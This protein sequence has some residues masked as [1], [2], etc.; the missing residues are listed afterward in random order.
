MAAAQ[1]A[2]LEITAAAARRLQRL[3]QTNPSSIG[4]RLSLKQRGC[5]GLSYTLTYATERRKFEEEVLTPDG[6][7]RVLID[8]RAMLHVVGTQMDFVDNELVSEF[9][10]NNPNEKGRCGCGESFNV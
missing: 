10:F 4:V 8:P 2:A 9:V 7:V 3:L 5:N 1:K 6:T